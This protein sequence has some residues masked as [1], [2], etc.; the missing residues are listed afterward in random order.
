VFTRRPAFLRLLCLLCPTLIGLKAQTVA[1]P[2]VVVSASRTAEAPDQVPFSVTALS[3]D[4]LRANPAST[5]DG[6]LRSVPGFSLFRRSD[7]LSANPT[8]QGVSLR[9]L[10]P[11]GAS[12][13]LVLLD[14]VPLNDPFGGWVAWSKVPRESLAGAEVVRGGGATAWGNAALGGIVQLFTENPGATRG[15]FAAAYG[16][17]STHSAELSLSQPLGP[18]TLQL[19]GRDFASDGFVLVAPE[20]RGPLDQPAASEHRWL[21]GR[22]RQ[23]IAG[24]AALTLTARTYEEDRNNGTPYQRNASQEDFVSVALA[25]ANG[26]TFTWDAVAYAQDQSFASTFSSVNATRT[27]ETPASDQFAVPA[28]AFGAA[29]TG[30]WQGENS[31]TSAGLDWRRVRG[32]TREHFT[33][34][35]GN[36]TRERRAGGAQEVAGIFVLHER[37]LAPDF[38][39]TVGGRLD[40]WNETD[41]HRRETERASGNVLRDDRYA[42]RDGVEFSPS[43]GLVWQPAAGWRLRAAA[44]HAFRRPTLNELY[45]PFRVGNVITEANPALATE[46]ATSAELGIEHT[47]NTLTLGATVFWNDLRDAVGNVTLFRGPGSF[48]IVGFVPA[49]GLGR[50]RLNLDRTRVQGLELSARWTPSATLTL[51]VDYLYNDAKVRAAP[52][53]PGLAGKRLA[54]VPRHSATLGA[55]WQPVK[56]LTLTPRMRFL[57]QQFEDDENLLRLGAALIF[58]LGVSYRFDERLEFTLNAENLTDERIE[59]GR[60]ADGLIN[61]GS[62]RL[63]LGGLR[64]T[65]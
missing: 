55:S 38:R 10:G 45:R 18:G 59:T 50:Q 5:A 4:R 60:S 58:D 61:T 31:R 51:N 11:S 13:S 32:E 25:G 19:L 21:S 23:E 40:R 16:E 30:T 27:A 42:D 3:G 53:A 65:W 62:P 57:G 47:S 35:A 14:G 36:F 56:S 15:R 26:G 41:G 12:R 44:Q 6:A 22:W 7:S 37:A 17:F 1:L 8:A 33:F 54:Q 2:T 28:K 24:G 49:G 43:A 48:P 39:A 29:W 34:S 9:G 46:H 64:F 52:V 63:V 20:D